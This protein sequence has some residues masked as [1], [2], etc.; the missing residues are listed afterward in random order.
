MRQQRALK[1]NK[2]NCILVI[3]GAW[4]ADQGSAWCL[5]RICVPQNSLSG[6]GCPRSRRILKNWKKSRTGLPRWACA[7][8]TWHV[9]EDWELLYSGKEEAKGGLQLPEGM[10]QR[11]WML[12]VVARQ[13]HSWPGSSVGNSPASKSFQMTILYFFYD[14]MNLYKFELK[15]LS[16]FLPQGL[17]QW[18]QV[19]HAYYRYV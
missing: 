7:H 17:L 12:Q 4:P 15:T 9:R 13:S 5:A 3:L 16:L 8:N 18:L 2:A 19:G 14:S 6:S 11:L 10:L 1:V